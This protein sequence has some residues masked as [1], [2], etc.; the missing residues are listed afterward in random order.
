MIYPYKTKPLSE[1]D[2]TTLLWLA[3]RGY[4][5]GVFENCD[6]VEPND[7]GDG[8]TLHFTEVSAWEIRDT[9]DDDPHAFLACC[10][11]DTLATALRSMIETIV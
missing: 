8:F 10:G 2:Y 9:I 3:D 11:S 7:D 1:R 5:G 4:D 6:A